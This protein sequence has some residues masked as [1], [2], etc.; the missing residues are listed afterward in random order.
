MVAPDIDR[1]T[2]TALKMNED[3]FNWRV[4][5]TASL[6][7]SRCTARIAHSRNA[8]ALTFDKR[9]TRKH[10]QKAPGTLELT[11]RSLSVAQWALLHDK[12][13]DCARVHLRAP[14]AARTGPANLTLGAV[15]HRHACV[16]LP[17]PA[18][19][20]VLQGLG[21]WV[22]LCCAETLLWEYLDLPARKL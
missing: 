22:A 7:L 6:D 15:A 17:D 4:D 19:R 3:V 2:K 8:R 21:L 14:A 12:N 1:S 18:S 16:I 20:C 5:A 11:A 13:R 10:D 9:G